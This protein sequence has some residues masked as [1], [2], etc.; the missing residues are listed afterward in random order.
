MPGMLTFDALKAAVAAGEIDTVVVAFTDMAGQLVGKRFHAEHF[1][2]FGARGD[3]RLLLS[4]GQRHRH[5]AG[6]RLRGGELG[7]GLRRFHPEARHGDAPPHPLARGDGARARRRRRPPSPRRRPAFAARDAEAPDRTPRQG[8]HEGAVRLGARILSVR[9][10]LRGDPGEGVPRPEDRRLLYRGLSYLPDCQGRAGDARDP[11]RIARRGHTGREFQGRVG[12]GP[13]RDQRPLRRGARDGRSP[14]ADQERLQGDRPQPRQGGH[15]HGEVALR[16]RGI[17]QPR[18]RFALGRRRP[19]AAV[20]RS[21][22]PPRHVGADAAVSGGATRPC[23]RN[24]V[25][26]GA[27][28]QF[29]QALPGRHVR[30]DEGCLE[31]RQ[32]HLRL[33]A[34]RRG[35]ESDPRRM[36]H[37]RR[38][39]QS[40]SRLR[41]A[42]GR[43]PRRHRAE[44][45]AGATFRR[46]RLSRRTIARDPE[47]PA[48]GDGYAGWFEDAARR[49]SGAPSSI[50]TSTPRNGSKA[51]TT[52]ASPTGN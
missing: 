38:R 42:V 33:P 20:R 27:V 40:L 3:P 7:P 28:H 1:V 17:V 23:A 46:R 29:L 31:R 8:G 50:T 10:E 51:N 37:R 4:V 30:A 36:P 45:R 43:G 24:H 9:R 11:Q 15:L 25:F 5:G 39:P 16:S 49:A 2:E 48:R 14:R 52:A 22:E 19:H 18:A 26:P 13:G 41:R 21:R 34:V 47:N 6:A 12:T 44:A 35:D 32:P